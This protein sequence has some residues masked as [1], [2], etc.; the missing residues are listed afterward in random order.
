MKPRFLAMTLFSLTC[1]TVV[2]AVLCYWWLP[3]QLDHTLKIHNNH[4]RML[5]SQLEKQRQ[6]NSV[7]AKKNVE[8]QLRLRTYEFEDALAA[9]GAQIECDSAIAKPCSADGP[10][11]IEEEVT[12]LERVRKD[13][14]RYREEIQRTRD[15]LER[16]N[17]ND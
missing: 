11:S 15:E 3:R 17:W 1:S 6:V 2:V 4:V 9:R 13:I 5:N 7:I 10:V 14:T 8:M 16:W 12:R